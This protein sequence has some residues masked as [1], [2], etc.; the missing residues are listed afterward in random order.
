MKSKIFLTL[1]V[2]LPILKLGAQ[3]MPK[4]GD[5]F[6]G[7]LSK[8]T[9]EV[10]P[11]GIKKQTTLVSNDIVFTL[12]P[13]KGKIVYISTKDPKF[14]KNS[15]YPGQITKWTDTIYKYTG[16]GNYIKID[17][18]WYG[19]VKKMDNDSIIITALFLYNFPCS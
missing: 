2:L 19:F 13:E 11:D 1:M 6:A 18:E 17:D 9:L 10:I 4:L 16:W 14:I 7:K 5:V 3:T 12:V 15:I 8:D